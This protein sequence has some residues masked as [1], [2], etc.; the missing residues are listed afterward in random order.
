MA[1]FERAWKP[2][3]FFRV[4]LPMLRSAD[5]R[6][7]DSVLHEPS[8]GLE[9]TLRKEAIMRNVFKF[10]AAATLTGALALAFSAPSKAAGGRHAAAAAG[11]VAGA[12]VGAAATGV[13]Y[14]N[15]YYYGDDYAY[16]PGYAYEAAPVYVAPSYSYDDYYPNRWQDQ[17]STNNFSISSQR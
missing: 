3:L 1:P 7:R 13:A 16:E 2:R 14:N 9:R 15:G 10:A 6:A 17:H 12:A 8:L 4:G 5:R 11:F